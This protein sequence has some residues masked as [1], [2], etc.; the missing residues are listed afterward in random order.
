MRCRESVTSVVRVN[1][2]RTTDDP[3]LEGTLAP[4]SALRLRVGTRRV[5]EPEQR[6]VILQIF[7]LYASGLGLK[8]IAKRLTA[9]R[10]VEPLPPRRTDGLTPPGWA[11][12]TVRTIL[13]RDLYRGVVVWKLPWPPSSCPLACVRR[14]SALSLTKLAVSLSCAMGKSP[15]SRELSIVAIQSRITRSWTGSQICMSQMTTCFGRRKS[16][17]ESSIANSSVW[18]SRRRSE[19]ATQE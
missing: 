7:E 15:P 12:S 2:S 1:H 17:E 4:C 18:S 19:S 9:E 6:A 11:P 3:R 16:H 13:C 5:I 8:A 10:A 14:S